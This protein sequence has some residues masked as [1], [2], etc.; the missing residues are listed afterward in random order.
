M[1]VCPDEAFWRDG[2]NAILFIIGLHPAGA[3]TLHRG[4]FVG[5]YIIYMSNIDYHKY[6]C[7]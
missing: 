6:K 3:A 2:D 4:S 7:E 1:D 5:Y